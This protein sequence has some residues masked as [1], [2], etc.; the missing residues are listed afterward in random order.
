[1][2]GVL[3]RLTDIDITVGGIGTDTRV[4][5]PLDALHLEVLINGV[6]ATTADLKLGDRVTIS[7]RPVTE[8]FATRL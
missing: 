4:T 6:P 7:G 1:M 8:I 5:V 3:Q 2:I